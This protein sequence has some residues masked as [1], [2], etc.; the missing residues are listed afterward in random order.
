[1]FRIFTAALLA[2]ALAGPAAAADAQP[3]QTIVYTHTT[4]IDGTGAPAQADM[5]IVTKAR[6]S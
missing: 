2:C 6:A 1:M 5:A 4:L 3:D